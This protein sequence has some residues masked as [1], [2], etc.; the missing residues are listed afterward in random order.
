MNKT[1]REIAESYWRAESERD[2]DKVLAHYHSDAVM[3]PPGQVLRGH[4][5]IRTFYEDSASRFPQV[6][7]QVVYE[8]TVGSEAVFEWEAVLIDHDGGRHPLKGVNVIKIEDGKYRY[9]HAYFDLSA[10][11]Q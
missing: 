4:D 7:V 10:L 5:E 9:V 2:I 3:E 8:L 6:E 1:P 11:P